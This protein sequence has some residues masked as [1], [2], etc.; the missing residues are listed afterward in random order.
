MSI[1]VDN[2]LEM[3]KLVDPDGVCDSIRYNGSCSTVNCEDCPF[4]NAESL[5]ATVDE[6]KRNYND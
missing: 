2:F 6:I 1:K 5:A 3:L 4:F